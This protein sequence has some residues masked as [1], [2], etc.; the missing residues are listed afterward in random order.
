MSVQANEMESLCDCHAPITVNG[1]ESKE[2][3]QARLSSHLL[4]VVELVGVLVAALVVLVKRLAED[5]DL[6]PILRGGG[7][8][9]HNGKHDEL[10]GEGEVI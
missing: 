10:L 3:F 5:L 8:R 9:G 4:S 1:A 6:R 7:S 2:D